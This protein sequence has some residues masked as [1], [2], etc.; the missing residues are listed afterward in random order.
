MLA[1]TL[2][3]IV[4]VFAGVGAALLLY[5]V[6]NKLAELLPPRIEERV[7]PLLYILPAYIAIIVFLIYP[8]LQ[9][10]VF[11]FKTKVGFPA[12]SWVGLDNYKNL[13]T[14]DKF[15]DTLFNTFLW[16]LVVPVATVILGLMV[17]V[18]AD[19]LRPKAEK[20]VKTLIFMPMAIS[21]V[22][23]ATVWG[24]IYDFRPAGRPQVGIQN[25]IVTAF[26]GD[27]VPWLTKSEWHFNSLLLMIM[28]LWLQVGFSMV[29][30]SSAVKGVPAE[31][32]EA[33]RIDGANERQIFT[34]VVV[35][36]IWPTVVTVYVTTLIGV[37]KLFD[38]VFV[39]TNGN[40]NTN[41]IGNEFYLQ[42]FNN[43]DKGTASA[44]VVMLIIAII[45]VMA[46]QV[47]NFKAQEAN[48]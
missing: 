32:L 48:A 8:A 21:F 38:I 46:Y 11:S 34:G 12:E 13:L 4:T 18:L 45:P 23:A 43:N 9:T 31:T 7:K 2:T 35:P 42:F 33:A 25:A 28:L 20:T 22:G 27:P 19:R 3:A 29:L 40:F 26:G 41:I 17:A 47:R 10:I 36:Q 24:L 44:I 6:L 39:M 14:S 5:W 1:K 16:I 30:L 15:Q 37:M